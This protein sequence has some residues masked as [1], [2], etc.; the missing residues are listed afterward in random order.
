MTEQ[1]KFYLSVQWR[2]AGSSF[3][4]VDDL[5]SFDCEYG[6][7]TNIPAGQVTLIDSTGEFTLWDRDGQYTLDSGGHSAYQR[8][9]PRAF[10]L[11]LETEGGSFLPAVSGRFWQADAAVD[12]RE[13]GSIVFEA[14]GPKLHRSDAPLTIDMGDTYIGNV[15]NRLIGAQGAGGLPWRLGDGITQAQ[16]LI[17]IYVNADGIYGSAGTDGKFDAL[18]ALAEPLARAADGYLLMGSAGQ[19]GVAS[20]LVAREEDQVWDELDDALVGDDVTISDSANSV[21][22]S[23]TATTPTGI[24]D[25]YS[26]T[27][28]LSVEAFGPRDAVLP[29]WFTTRP[30][31]AYLQNILYRRVLPQITMQVELVLAAPTHAAMWRMVSAVLFSNV[32]R[33]RSQQRT[34]LIVGRRYSWT[35]GDVPRCTLDMVELPFSRS[36]DEAERRGVFGRGTQ[37]GATL[38]PTHR[39]VQARS[40]VGWGGVFRS[41]QA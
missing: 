16:P 31:D 4:R 36:P 25:W 15:V 17:P 5:L 34:F 13:P 29:R 24:T 30:H 22:N 2:G 28:V 21:V 8:R 27:H 18:S 7:R 35:L 39:G 19:V 41:R 26:L 23:A 37:R 33:S 38:V 6:S 11:Y 32:I 20:A 1:V 14:E 9:I 40:Q 3:E 10:R 12:P